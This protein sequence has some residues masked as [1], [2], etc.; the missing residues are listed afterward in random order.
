MI[1]KKDIGLFLHVCFLYA[2]KQTLLWLV[3][4]SDVRSVDCF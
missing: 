4:A 1:D 2:L 3:A